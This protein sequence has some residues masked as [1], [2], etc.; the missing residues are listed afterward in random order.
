MIHTGV[1]GVIIDGGST[2][3]ALL[4]RGW[5]LLLHP[6]RDRLSA[7][8]RRVTAVNEKRALSLVLDFHSSY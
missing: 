1:E 6:C 7:G 5:L 8:T 4:E 2:V 3:V